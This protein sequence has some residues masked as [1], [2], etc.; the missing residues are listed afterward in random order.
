MINEVFKKKYSQLNKEQKEAVDTIDGPVMVIAGPGTGKTQILTLRIANIIL[1]TDTPAEAVL[2]LTFTEA[3]VTAMRKRLTEIIGTQAYQVKITT[4]HSFCNDIIRN[5]PEDFG[6]IIGANP[7]T[8]PEKITMMQEI[9]TQANLKNLTTFGDKFYYLKAIMGGID[10]LKR[11]GV[12]PEKFSDLLD[13]EEK[14]FANIEDLYNEKGAYKGKMKTKYQDLQ[15]HIEK[16]KE[17]LKVYGL[18]RESL[19]KNKLYDFTD[20]IVEAMS[21]L[22]KNEDLLMRLQEQHQYILVDEHQDTN[23]AQNKILEL[24]SNFHPDPNLFVV[25]DEKQAIYRFQGASLENFLYFK[26]L[27]PAA[28]LINLQQNY[29]STQ[30]ILDSAFSFMKKGIELKSHQEHQET[31]IQLYEFGEVDAENYFVAENIREK[32]EEGTQPEE[33]AIIYRNNS[34]ALPIASMLSKFG[35]PYISESNQSVLDDTDI[36]KLIYILRAIRNFGEPMHFL[37]ALHVDFLGAAPLD[38]F[39]LSSYS[40]THRK[41]PFEILNSE[42]E[43]KLSGMNETSLLEL[44]KKFSHWNEIANNN[45][46]MIAFE[47]IIRDSGMLTYILKRPGAVEKIAK[48]R[49]LFNQ[50][51]QMISKNRDSNL[52]DFIDQI[53]LAIENNIEIKTSANFDTKGKVQLMTAHRS[54]G[55]EFEQVYLIGAYDGHWGNKTRRE[56]IKLPKSIFAL[57]KASTI[58]ESEED[59]ERNLF[60]VALTRAKKSVNISYSKTNLIK[61]EQLLSYFVQEIKPELVEKCDA[62]KYESRFSQNREILFA[63]PKISEP[64]LNDKELVG[65]LFERY[66]LSPTHLNNYLKCPWKYFYQSLIG[67]PEAP[68]RYFALGNA[69]HWGLKVYFDHLSKD[70]D[71]GQ[72]FLI[73]KFSE[74]LTKQPLTQEEYLDLSAHGKEILAGWFDFYHDTFKNSTLNE[75]PVSDIELAPGVS[76]NGKIDKIEVNDGKNVNVVDYKTGKPKSRKEMEAD[77]DYERQLTFYKLLLSKSGKFNMESGEIDFISPDNKAKWHKEKFVIQP[78]QVEELE[79]TIL[80]VADEIRS[81]AFWDKFCDEPDCEYCALRKMLS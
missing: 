1:K 22:E 34:D 79:Q 4:F 18:Y 54:K 80:K 24:L 20:M 38:L 26:N 11:E 2:A 53:E 77:G 57:S 36:K 76:I 73:K 28:K 66:G 69:V 44:A 64:S 30:T 47:E 5:Y 41:N 65:Q 59:D 72:N 6:H 58:E 14:N 32:I 67:L 17:L 8:E 9:I 51:S 39:K 68:N 60:Y 81:L 7:I 13:Q 43:S 27:Y 3:G 63:A 10:N 61:K 78:E 29:R 35:I 75:Y 25:G 19:I 12:T 49:N 50:V 21:V 71:M 40:R 31:K 46:A 15:K 62:E 48:V 70:E 23:N 33:I 37:R 42:E 16:N 52:I 45:S 55:L 56:L 74:S